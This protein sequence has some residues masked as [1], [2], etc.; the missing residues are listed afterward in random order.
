MTAFT[1]S[2]P[3]TLDLLQLLE[4]FVQ[5]TKTLRNRILGG[6]LRHLQGQQDALLLLVNAGHFGNYS[7]TYHIM[8]FG[9]CHK[10]VTHCL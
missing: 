4:V 10:L 2:T 7:L 6:A 8:V 9:L 5:Q 3:D 1:S